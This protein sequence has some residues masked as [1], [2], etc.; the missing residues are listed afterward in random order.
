MKLTTSDGKIVDESTVIDSLEAFESSRLAQAFRCLPDDTAGGDRLERSYR[1]T[2]RVRRRVIRLLDP[3]VVASGG[4]PISKDLMAASQ[5]WLIRLFEVVE[6]A[7][8]RLILVRTL[9]SL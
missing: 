8:P 9:P 7:L 1:A 4:Q 6:S 3:S 2:E 5:T